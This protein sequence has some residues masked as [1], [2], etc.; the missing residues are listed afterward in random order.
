MKNLIFLLLLLGGVS[1][2]YGSNLPISISSCHCFKDRVYNPQK[3]FA[4]DQYLL[5]TSFNS[6]L[7]ANFHLSKSQIVMMKMKGGVAPDDL[8]LGLYLARAGGVELSSVLAVLANGGSWQQILDS[9]NLIGKQEDSKFLA[10]LRTALS[11]KGLAGELVTDQLL[12]EFF[13]VSENDIKSLRIA[14][15]GSRELVL[16]Y[17]LE[18]YAKTGMKAAAILAMYNEGERSWAEIVHGFGLSPKA[19]GKLLSDPG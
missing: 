13:K 12:K 16:L 8:L 7:A 19:T 17:I 15:A 11:T 1:T 6:F 4:A 9:D 10:T 3:K 2:A 14:G 18:R 5:T